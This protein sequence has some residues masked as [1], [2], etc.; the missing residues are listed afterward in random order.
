MMAKGLFFHFH[1]D[2][3]YG[4]YFLSMLKEKKEDQINSLNSYTI[5]QLEQFY[6]SDSITFDPHKTGY[7]P[8]T[9][10]GVFYRNYQLRNNL[11]FSAPYIFSGFEPNVAIYGIE[12]SKPGAAVSAVYL[13]L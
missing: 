10:G 3:A 1:I 7:V 9:C 6:R 5:T 8:Y 11:T 12:G 4:A 2:G 13:S